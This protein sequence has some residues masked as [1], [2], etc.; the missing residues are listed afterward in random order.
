MPT[1]TTVSSYIL[2]R[3]K[4]AG[5]GHIF[6]VPGDYDADGLTDAA[7][8]RPSQGIWYIR[9]TRTGGVF[10]YQWG[11]NTDVPVPGDFDG[12]GKTDL[13]VFRPSNGLWFIRY[14]RDGG[15]VALAWGSA[16]DIPVLK[17]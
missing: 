15:T 16:S 13:A 2:A 5:V 7:V 10:G 8:F 12:D 4:Q 11:S 1:T 3:L 9:Y 14:S 17:R 6:A